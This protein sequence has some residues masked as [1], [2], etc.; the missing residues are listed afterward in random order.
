MTM[1][2]TGR[3]LALVAGC[4]AALAGAAVP[5]GWGCGQGGGTS[6]PHICPPVEDA[7]GGPDPSLPAPP[8]AGAVS[9]LL[10]HRKS[11]VV[12]A[13][14]G[15]GVRVHHMWFTPAPA[16]KQ[17]TA[18]TALSEAQRLA[19]SR[20]NAATRA[21]SVAEGMS[22]PETTPALV[23]TLTVPGGCALESAK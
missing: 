16:P 9:E 4:A 20:V 3:R 22:T 1:S 19:Q 11:G 18:R 15:N 5:A 7:S 8:T 6:A 13:W 21:V 17:E 2:H 14:L 12:S 23:V 10:A